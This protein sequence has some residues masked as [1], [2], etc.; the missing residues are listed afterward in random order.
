MPVR[1]IIRKHTIPYKGSGFGYCHLIAPHPHVGPHTPLRDLWATNMTLLAAGFDFARSHGMPTPDMTGWAHVASDDWT[2]SLHI[3]DHR[4]HAAFV[5][6]EDHNPR[7][8]DGTIDTSHYKGKS[9][10]IRAKLYRDLALG[11]YWME[12]E[13]HLKSYKTSVPQKISKWLG[14][15]TSHNIKYI[16]ILRKQKKI[17]HKH[18]K[19]HIWNNYLRILFNTLPTDHRRSAANMAI[20][21]RLALPPGCYFCGQ[22]EDSIQHIFQDCPVTTT[23]FREVM[24]AV[25]SV[26]PLNLFNILLLFDPPSDP[27]KSI[28]IAHFI[29]SV[30]RLRGDYFATLSNTPPAHIASKRIT[31]TTLDSLPLNASKGGQATKQSIINALATAMA[32]ILLNGVAIF[33]DGSEDKQTGHCGAGIW[34][35][36]KIDSLGIDTEINISIAL[37]LGNNNLGEMVGLLVAYHIVDALVQSLDYKGDIFIF[38]D[39]MCCIAFLTVGWPKPTEDYAPSYITKELYRKYENNDYHRLYWVKGH[40]NLLGNDLADKLAKMAAAKSLALHLGKG[41]QQIRFN[42][43]PNGKGNDI[44]NN[45]INIDTIIEILN[46]YN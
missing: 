5:A 15:D 31:E 12:R 4:A 39:S 36:V 40:S 16:N 11:G 9:S 20:A 46:S 17:I 37:G 42:T 22:G 19:P 30:W 44:V 27:S 28:T 23:S 3:H 6:M 33:S 41:E 10:N 34:V 1:N 8:A 35:R 18:C 26:T 2:G 29:T 32:T 14:N 21:P 25:K 43:N 7:Q 38:S 45:C 13:S 24:T